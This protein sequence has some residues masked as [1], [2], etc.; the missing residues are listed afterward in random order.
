M[1]LSERICLGASELGKTERAETSAMGEPDDFRI[2]ERTPKIA[3][4][5]CEASLPCKILRWYFVSHIGKMG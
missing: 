2:A 3:E 1:I 4:L 5:V